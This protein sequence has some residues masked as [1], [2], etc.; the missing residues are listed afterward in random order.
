MSTIAVDDL[1]QVAERVFGT[2][3]S[4]L[5]G[6]A[7][8]KSVPELKQT[9]LAVR[10]MLTSKAAR[11]PETAYERQPDDVD[12][13][14]VWSAGE[15]ASHIAG[16][17]IW[18]DANLRRITGRPERLPSED[19]KSAADVRVRSKDEAQE[20]LAIADRE[21]D[22]ILDDIQDNVATSARIDHDTFGNVGVKGWLLLTALH[23]GE[24]ANQMRELGVT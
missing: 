15:I 7:D 23:E 17:M 10:R 13:G 16:T 14:D 3:E 4:T 1:M 11:L 6:E 21:L 22:R 12:G 8:D 2:R 24:H 18:T 20:I 9:V 19:L 5:E